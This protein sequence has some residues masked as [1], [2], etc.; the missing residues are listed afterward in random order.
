MIVETEPFFVI[1]QSVIVG[2][3]PERIGRY[4]DQGFAHH[5]DIPAVDFQAVVEHVVVRVHVDRICARWA[6]V[7]RELAVDGIG[8]SRCGRFDPVVIEV[9]ARIGCIVLKR[10]H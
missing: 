9:I 8:A 2:I 4:D 7:R 5:S 3:T 1:G 10:R 6:C